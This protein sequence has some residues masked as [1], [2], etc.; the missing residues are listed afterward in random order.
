MTLARKCHGCGVRGLFVPLAPAHPSANWSG[1][2]QDCCLLDLVVSERR[3]LA[4]L[5]F[6][7][8]V[9]PDLFAYAPIC[10]EVGAATPPMGYGWSGA[11]AVAEYRGLRGTKK[12]ELIESN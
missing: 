9:G 8:R 3:R 11:I 12:T 4:M 6:G 2:L 1:P 5:A 10:P 7:K